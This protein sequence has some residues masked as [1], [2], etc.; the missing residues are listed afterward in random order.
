MT[1]QLCH[2][3]VSCRDSRCTGRGT[4]Y[5]QVRDGVLLRPVLL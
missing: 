4:D 3:D 2:D 1:D 5:L